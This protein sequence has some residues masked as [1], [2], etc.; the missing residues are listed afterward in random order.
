F[1]VPVDGTTKTTGVILAD[2]VKSLDWKARAARTVDSV[3]GETVT[4]VVDMV[5]KIIKA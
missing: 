2:Q 4:T 3:S 1:E 5:S